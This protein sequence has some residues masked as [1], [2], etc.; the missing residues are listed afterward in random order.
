MLHLLDPGE[1][2]AQ[3]RE[4]VLD[5]GADSS[6]SRAAPRAAA[7]AGPRRARGRPG[8]PPGADAVRR[9]VKPVEVGATEPASVRRR[10]PRR[11]RAARARRRSRSASRPRPRR[12]RAASAATASSR[13]APRTRGPPPPRSPTRAPATSTRGSRHLPAVRSARRRGSEGWRS[14][15]KSCDRQ[16]IYAGEDAAADLAERLAAEDDLVAVLEEGA[17]VPSPSRSGSPPFHVS[18]IRLPSL[19]RSDRRSCPRP[20]G[21]RC[22]RSP[23]STSHARAAAASSSRGRGRCRAR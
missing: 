19:P 7:R 5:P 13:A 14:A 12:T 17:L 22:G 4:L 23:R 2:A 1:A 20:S 6:A 9:R 16:A 8:T 11:R 10:L 15:A 3:A 21:R 18:S